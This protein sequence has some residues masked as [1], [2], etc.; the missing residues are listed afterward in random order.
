MKVH[1]GLILGVGLLLAADT[2]SDKAKEEAKF[3]GTWTVSKMTSDGKEKEDTGGVKFVIKGNT[4][5]IRSEGQDRKMTFKIDPTKDPK[6][7][8]LVPAEGKYKG[9]T[10]KGIYSFD[11]DTLKISFTNP[12]EDRP[13]KFDSEEGSGIIAFEFEKEKE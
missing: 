11:N 1:V 13:T 4:I 12:G 7:I 8:D 2:P 6:V 5:T 10:L 3:K 9:K